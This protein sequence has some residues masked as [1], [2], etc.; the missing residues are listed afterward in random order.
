LF[1]VFVVQFFKTLDIQIPNFFK[2]LL[3]F[4]FL[5][6]LSHGYGKLYTLACK[7]GKNSFSVKYV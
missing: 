7:A 1:K 2:K 6:L 4:I 3:L 5:I